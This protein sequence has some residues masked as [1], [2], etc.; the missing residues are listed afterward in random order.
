MKTPDTSKPVS[1]ALNKRDFIGTYPKRLNTLTAEVLMQLLEGVR[2][3]GLDAVYDAN[4]TR[5]AGVIHRLIHAYGWPIE[6][7]DESVQ[8]SDGRIAEICRYYLSNGVI[9]AAMEAGARE[10]CEG[11]SYARE[12]LRRAPKQL[13]VKTMQAGAAQ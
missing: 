8:T 7:R 3:T 10:F 9:E 6:K 5:L 11:V 1:S 12:M 4:T 2:K 13:P